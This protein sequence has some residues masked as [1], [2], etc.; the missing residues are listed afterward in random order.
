MYI[1]NAIDIL[2]TTVESLGMSFVHANLKEANLKLDKDITFPVYVHISPTKMKNK[3]DHPTL[4]RRKIDLFGMILTKV[5]Q[6]TIDYDTMKVEAAVNECRTLGD[7]LAQNL[8][9]T[10]VADFETIGKEDQEWET[11]ATYDEFDASLHGCTFTYTWPVINCTC[12]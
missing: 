12:C 11:V 9:K 5:S 3:Q 10:A 8:Q 7:K 4:I 2:K 1:M 6:S